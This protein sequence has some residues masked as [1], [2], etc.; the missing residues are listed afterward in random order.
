MIIFKVLNV[1]SDAWESYKICLI[2]K[3]I[4]GKESTF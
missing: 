2:L 4:F 1:D 3:M